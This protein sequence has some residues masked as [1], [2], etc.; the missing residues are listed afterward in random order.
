M[1]EVQAR[2]LYKDGKTWKPQYTPLCLC[3]DIPELASVDRATLGRMNIMNLNNQFVNEPDAN[4]KFQRQMNIDLPVILNNDAEYKKSFMWILI[5]NYKTMNNNL[6]SK[7]CKE[8]NEK[9]V[10]DNNP[11]LTYIEERIEK[12]NG[13]RIQCKDVYADYMNYCLNNN[14]KALSNIAFSK[15]MKFNDFTQEVN[16]KNKLFWVNIKINDSYDM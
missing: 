6:I 3:N 10:T 5:E 16:R 13:E 8:A 4:N 7:N 14:I 12:V 1:D 15:L 9:Y 2:G 11:I